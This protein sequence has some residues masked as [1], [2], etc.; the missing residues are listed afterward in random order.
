VNNLVKGSE[1]LTGRK[2]GVIYNS[3]YHTE[4]RSQANVFLLNRIFR[5]TQNFRHINRA[6]FVVIIGTHAISLDLVC[7]SVNLMAAYQ[8]HWLTRAQKRGQENYRIAELKFYGFFTFALDS[9]QWLDSNAGR[10]MPG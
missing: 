10:H 7:Y 8:L 5:C 9:S 1:E 3:K 6:D 4:V 2:E